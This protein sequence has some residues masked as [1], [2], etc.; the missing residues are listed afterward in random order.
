MRV[1][2]A[3]AAGAIGRRLIPQLVA[4]GHQVTASTRGANKLDQLRALGAEPVIV[5]GLDATAVGEAIARSEP[6]A[7]VHQMTALAGKPNLRNF[8]KW[9]ATTNKLRTAG[10]EHLLAAA[11]A[12]GVGKFVAQSYTG[13]SNIREGGPVKTEDDPFD[14][15]PAK[16]Q[17]ESMAGLQFLDRVIPA[18]P[19]EGIVLRY[20]SFYGPG[21][22]ESLVELVRKRQMPIIGDGAGV[23]S[24]IHLDDAAAATVAAVERGH[25]GIY[26][27]TDDEPAAVS[28]WLPYLAEVVGAKKPMHV[29]GWLGRLAAGEVTV[30]WM[31]QG[32]GASNVKAR[33]ELDWRPAWSTWRDGFR[34][35]LTDSGRTLR[36]AGPQEETA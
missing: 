18:A 13:W 15:Q 14:P 10:T 16:Y 11:K 5:D 31:T 25:R 19:F 23:W 29:P 36:A 30:R 21:A 1:F 8:D 7:I 24:W 20:G 32:R 17:V 34:H 12:A 28:E 4:R 35:G 2:V 22:S 33:R 27:I 9:F 3:G 26:N 6:D